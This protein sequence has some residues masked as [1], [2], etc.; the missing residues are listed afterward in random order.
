MGQQIFPE[1]W[2][3]IG[4]LFHRTRTGESVALDD[5][6]IPLDRNG[7]LENCYFTFSYSAIH[8]ETGGVGGMLAV[9]AETT[10]RASRTPPRRTSSRRSP[11]QACSIR[12]RFSSPE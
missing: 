2:P 6:L 5:Q 8:D 3:F 7:Y 11:S 4:P 9:V 12:V 1:A 10:E